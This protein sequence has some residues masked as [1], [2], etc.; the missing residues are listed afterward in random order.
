MKKTKAESPNEF[1]LNLKLEQ[2]GIKGLSVID[3]SIDGGRV[4][5]F[6]LQNLSQNS[7]LNSDN[8][9]VICLDENLEEFMNVTLKAK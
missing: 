2:A 4:D 9:N 6:S 1:D 5:I 7:N 3:F 8:I